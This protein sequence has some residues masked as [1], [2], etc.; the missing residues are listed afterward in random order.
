MSM[1]NGLFLAAISATSGMP[2]V[3]ELGIAFDVLVAMV[4]FG[5]FFF[6]IRESIDSLD[7]DRLNRSPRPWRIEVARCWSYCRPRRRLRPGPATA[8]ALGRPAEHRRIG[9]FL[10]AASLTA[11]GGG[12]ATRGHR[13]AVLRRRVQCVSGG[14]DHVRRADHLDLLAALHAPRAA[15]TG[16]TGE[17]GMRVYHS[18]VPGIHG[19]HAG[20]AHHRQPRAAVGGGGGRDAGDGAAGVVVSHARRRGGGLEVLHPVRCRHRPGA[21]RY[22][23]DLLRGRARA[24]RPASGLLWTHLYGGLASSIP[25]SC[26][27]PLSSCWWAMAPRSVWRPCTT[28]CP[29]RTP[30]VPRP[31]RPCSPDCC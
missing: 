17:R 15:S 22:G 18:H 2:M 26:G 4:L 9:R 8:A 13:R 7:V 12:W 28:G 11:P 1:E 14:A 20:G 31:C 19:H 27:S 10:A 3:V 5:V 25:R 30:R 16:K 6:Q 24:G 21:V 29:T 23:P